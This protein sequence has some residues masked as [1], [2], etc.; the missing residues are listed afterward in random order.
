MLT[1]LEALKY[2]EPWNREEGLH[3]YHVY[4]MYYIYIDITGRNFCMIDRKNIHNI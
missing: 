2:D 4:I 3:V 1:T